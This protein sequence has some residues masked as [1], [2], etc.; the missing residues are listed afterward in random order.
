TIKVIASDNIGKDSVRQK[1]DGPVSTDWS[2]NE[3][4]GGFGDGGAET[5]CGKDKEIFRRDFS[6]TSEIPV[7][8]TPPLVMAGT[9]FC[10]KVS[11]L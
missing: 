2:S 1:D 8:T 3:G 10:T 5:P 6:T 7:D 9:K 4:P 11:F